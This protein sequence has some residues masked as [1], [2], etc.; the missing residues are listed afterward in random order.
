MPKKEH[1]QKALV[2]GEVQQLIDLSDALAVEE[3][4]LKTNAENLVKEMVVEV[5]ADNTPEDKLATW[6]ELTARIAMVS[7]DL[8]T[9]LRMLMGYFLALRS[10][11]WEDSLK[12]TDK[13]RLNYLVENNPTMFAV[14]DKALE[15][16]D[17]DLYNTAIDNVKGRTEFNEGFIE[18]LKETELY[19]MEEDVNVEE[20]TD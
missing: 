17:K 2:M 4:V 15:P 8:T 20:E 13:E 11:G 14:K 1:N 9:V 6:R 18:R 7:E 5:K 3:Q 10:L 16:R 12:D 19:S